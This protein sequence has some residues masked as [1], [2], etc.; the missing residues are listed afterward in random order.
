MKDARC[1]LK[2]VLQFIIEIATF[3]VEVMV[4]LL[5]G[6]A[7]LVFIYRSMVKGSSASWAKHLLSWFLTCDALSGESFGRC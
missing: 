7:V 5:S 3:E 6:A 1:E 4:L 2:A